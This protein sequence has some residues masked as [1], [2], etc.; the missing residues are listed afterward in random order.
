MENTDT[1]PDNPFDASR[2][3]PAA[4]LTLRQHA[5]NLFYTTFYFGIFL[6]YRFLHRSRFTFKGAAYRYH[7]GWYNRTWLTERCVEIPLILAY[8]KKSRGAVLEVGNVLS[9]YVRVKH[10]VVDK[11]EKRPGV[12][13]DD[14]ESFVAP[15]PFDLIIS[16]STLEHVG[17]HD[18]VRDP[19]K[20]LRCIDHLSAMLSKNGRFIFTVPLGLN[21]ALDGYLRDGVI[22]CS[23]ISYLSR[24]S[25]D[26]W[27]ETP[28]PDFNKVTARGTWPAASLIAVACIEKG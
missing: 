18:D 28:V 20:V 17:F 23:W 2:Q 27:E 10:T 1:R 5:G 7:Y 19:E 22:P 26:K 13:N 8:L 24:I 9:H 12:Q 6:C 11:F 4:R 16:I 25:I 14:I 21:S 15:M 3:R